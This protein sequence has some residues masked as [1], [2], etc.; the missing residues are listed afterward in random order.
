MVYAGEQPLRKYRAGLG[1]TQS[2]VCLVREGNGVER[3]EYYEAK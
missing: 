1:N 2:C 3:E